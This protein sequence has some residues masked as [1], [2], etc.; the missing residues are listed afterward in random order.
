LISTRGKDLPG[1]STEE[2]LKVKGGKRQTE[3]R[4]K[5]IKNKNRKEGD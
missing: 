4:G 5:H 1:L 3:K 2:K